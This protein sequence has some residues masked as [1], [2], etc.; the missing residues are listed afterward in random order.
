MVGITA[1]RGVFG[2][3]QP[4]RLQGPDGRELGRGL[5]QLSSAAV[6]RALDAAP[7]AGPSPVVVHRDALVLHSR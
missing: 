4:V 6:Q 2:A 7:A 5:C 3:N 1:V